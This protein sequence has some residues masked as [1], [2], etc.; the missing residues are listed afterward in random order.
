MQELWYEFSEKY[1]GIFPYMPLVMI[2]KAF[3]YYENN[4]EYA[5]EIMQKYNPNMAAR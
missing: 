3:W 5:D 1:D 2:L 4:K